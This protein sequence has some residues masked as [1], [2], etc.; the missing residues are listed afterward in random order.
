MRIIQNLK[1]VK[2]NH[3]KR[4]LILSHPFVLP[5]VALG[6]KLHIWEK[7]E[8]KISINIRKR[9]YTISEKIMNLVSLLVSGGNALDHMELLRREEVLPLL[10]GME[11]LPAPNTLGE[12]LR[13]LGKRPLHIARLSRIISQSI[14]EFLLRRKPRRITFDLDASLIESYKRDAKKTYKGFRGYDPLLMVIAEYNLVYMGIFR[15]GNISPHSHNLSLLRAC[16]YR[17][18]PEL[19]GRVWF[20]SDSAAY[21]RGVMRF[22]DDHGIPF[23]IGV[24]MDSS[25]R[26]ELRDIPEG[27]WEYFED[28]VEVAESVHVLGSD[29]KRMVGPYRLIFIRKR[30]GRDLFGDRY[31]YFGIITNLPED[32][33]ASWVVR[34]YNGRCDSENV[35]KDLK[36]NLGMER[37]PCGDFM[38]DAVYFQVLLLA[39][40]LVKGV[41]LYLLPVGWGRYTVKTL[42]FLLGVGVYVVRHARGI[43]LAFPRGYRYLRIW[44]GMLRVLKIGISS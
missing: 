35:F 42:R 32:Y 25:V 24:D 2:I 12:T 26:R 28:G 23:C 14:N 37:V 29:P 31:R 10:F 11:K 17:L 30:E 41:Q 16:Y 7:I 20:R 19:R 44:G 3:L 9:G 22:L 8:K 36:G 38:A 4:G 5:V 18:P 43:V 40:W 39:Q 6:Q 13:K 1:K 34:W 27:A 15:D 21:Q 33:S